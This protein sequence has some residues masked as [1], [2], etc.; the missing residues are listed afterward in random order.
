MLA[1]A[2]AALETSES[3]FA[4]SI[5]PHDCESV[6][7]DTDVHGSLHTSSALDAAGAAALMLEYLGR[8]DAELIVDIAELMHDSIYV[9]VGN[10]LN[11]DQ[12]NPEFENAIKSSG[13]MSAELAHQMADLDFLDSLPDDQSTGFIRIL[14]FWMKKSGV[15]PF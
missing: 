10:S 2:W 6:A 1:K 9:F 5:T 14:D 12:N 4:V 7:P 15:N 11:I 8:N 13:L 3:K